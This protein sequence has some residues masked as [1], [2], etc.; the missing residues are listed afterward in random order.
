M[1]TGPCKCS[2]INPRAHR[3]LVSEDKPG[4][5]CVGFRTEGVFYGAVLHNGYLHDHKEP[6]MAALCMI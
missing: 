2:K 3:L 6:S 5:A 1:R 4:L